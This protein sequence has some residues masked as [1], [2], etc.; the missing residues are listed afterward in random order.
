MIL[1]HSQC[2]QS[3]V[4]HPVT[5]RQILFAENFFFTFCGSRFVSLKELNIFAIYELSGDQLNKI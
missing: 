2:F 5:K 4:T 1:R 3:S